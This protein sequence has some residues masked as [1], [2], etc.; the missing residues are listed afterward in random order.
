FP[1]IPTSFIFNFTPCS[2]CSSIAA[3]EYKDDH[4]KVAFLEKAKGSADYH[5]ILDFLNGSHLR[6]AL[7]HC[8]P[9][10]FDSL[11]KQF[12]TSAML[13]KDGS[14]S[15]ICFNVDNTN[16][17][18]DPK[19]LLTSTATSIP[20]E[21]TSVPTVV[22]A[23]APLVASIPNVE[24]Q[25]GSIAAGQAVQTESTTTT[26]PTDSTPV[27]SPNSSG[28]TKRRKRTARKRAPPPL[29]DM[30]DQSF[31]KFDSGSESEG[32]LVAWAKLAAWEVVSTPL[33]EVNALYRVDR[34]TKYFTHLREIL[35]LVTR[36]DLIHLY[37]L[38]DK[39][40]ETNVA[41]GVGLLLWGDL[42]VLFDSTEGGAG[43]LKHK[44]ELARDVVG[45]DLTTAE[46]LISFIKSQLIVA[47]A[48]AS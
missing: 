46:Q 21:P 1:N 20:A 7:T 6:Y 39:F 10:T 15:L 36:Q 4:N 16:V 48:S 8:P 3:L 41:T 34:F 40:Y 28:Q 24:S 12:W 26:I 32:E 22:A 27:T 13:H 25:E 37:H 5:Q 11:V 44:L 30:D 43:M 2:Y 31:L 33:G 42:K 9:I 14:L 35:H 23:G 38:V 45:N 47:H 19:L 29:L 17:D 18:G